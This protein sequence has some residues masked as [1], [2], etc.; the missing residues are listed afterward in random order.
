MVLLRCILA[1]M[2]CVASGQAADAWQLIRFEGRDYIPLDNIAKFYGFPPPPPVVATPPQS[3]TTSA[4]APSQPQTPAPQTTATPPPAS[5]PAPAAPSAPSTD[6]STADAAS[7][8]APDPAAAIQNATAQPPAPP[9]GHVTADT[10]IIPAALEI[11]PSNS[12]TL[13]N[14]KA[15]MTL[16][17]N[18]RIALI[19]GVKQWLSFPAVVQDGKLLISRIDLAK[20]LE[21]RLRP[22]KIEGLR[23]VRT[24]VLD[25]GHGGH[26]RGAR[27]RYG[28]EKDFAL[29]IALRVKQR[30]ERRGIKVLMTRSSDVFIPLHERPRVANNT[31]DSIFVSIHFN[32]ASSNPLARGFEIFSVAP[33]GAPATNDSKFSIRHLRAEPANVVDTHSTALA[34]SIYHSMLGNVPMEDRGL[35]HARFAVIRLCTKPS[36][37]VECGFVSNGPESALIGSAAW[38]QQVADSIAIGIESYKELAEERNAPKLMAEY[39][40]AAVA[41]PE[42][43]EEPAPV[44][45]PTPPQ[46]N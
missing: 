25:P 14:E 1:L 9:G 11:T 26:D 32:A 5:T 44:V 37:L 4:P 7:A 12:V 15:R 46:Q 24:V 27:S 30:L 38:R 39:R 33:R 2:A 3:Q 22:E 18:S 8:P 16:T 21:P 17:A 36:V 28:Y 45:Q 35:K 34:G 23:P 20:T 43:P 6:A 40:K 10:Q 42:K 41:D 13:E 19:N 29:D 31:P